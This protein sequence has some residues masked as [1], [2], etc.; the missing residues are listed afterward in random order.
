LLLEVLKLTD[1]L[2][3]AVDHLKLLSSRQE[4]ERILLGLEIIFVPVIHILVAKI[5]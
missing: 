2:A 4:V 3:L 5:E 1:D